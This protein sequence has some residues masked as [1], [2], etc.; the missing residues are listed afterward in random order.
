M[1][2]WLYDLSHETP[3]YLEYYISGDRGCWLFDWTQF[4]LRLFPFN[5]NYVKIPEKALEDVFYL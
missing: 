5:L 4:K 3:K 2:N 1:E